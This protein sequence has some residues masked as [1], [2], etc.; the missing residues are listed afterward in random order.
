MDT[1]VTTA[2][3]VYWHRDL[4]PV[5]A[6]VL[7]EGEMEATSERVAGTIA[8]RDLLWERCLAGLK[9]TA[10]SRLEQEVRRRGGRYAHVLTE[11]IDTRRDDRTGETW[12]HGR[13]DYVL[14]V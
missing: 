11:A 1:D 14:M 4:P 8:N 5:S 3:V 7:G 6:R 9:A 13:F 10:R 12:L 2:P